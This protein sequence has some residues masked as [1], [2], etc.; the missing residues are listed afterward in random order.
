MYILDLF[1]YLVQY[2][3]GVVRFRL[4]ISYLIY[5][6]P[7]ETNFNISF[8]SFILLSGFWL[9]LQELIVII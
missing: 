9:V 6:M 3:K 7:K 4:F 1:D 5:D 8:P 2:L